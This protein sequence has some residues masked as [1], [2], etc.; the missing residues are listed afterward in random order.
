MNLADIGIVCGM[1]VSL[2]GVGAGGADYYLK[3]EYVPVSSLIER[4]IRGLKAEMREMEYDRD[5]GGLSDK[6][7]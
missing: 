7:E 5:H 2:M 1:C 6:D 4:D 3:H